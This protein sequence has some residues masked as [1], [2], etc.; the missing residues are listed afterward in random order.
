MRDIALRFRPVA[1]LLVVGALA[2]APSDVRAQ[3]LN[4][5]ES[6]VSYLRVLGTAG[7]AHGPSFTVLQGRSWADG[8]AILVPH[9][10]EDRLTLSPT[11]TFADGFGDLGDTR[12]RLVGNSR[13]PRG[14]NDGAVWS[15]RGLT[16][17]LDTRATLRWHGLSAT[18]NPSV[19]FNQ[20]AS[21][22]LV[23]VQPAGQPSYAYPW[24]R[25]DYPQRFGPQSYWTF[26]LGQS[27]IALDW[28]SG[29]VSFGN[30]SLWW[31]P[32]IRNAIVL[33][34]NAPGFLHATLGTNRPVDIGIGTLEGQWIW[35]GLGQS[36]YFD[37][38]APTDRYITGLVLAY[39]PIWL[40]GFTVGGTR[41]FQSYVPAG[42][43]PL[44]DYFL[45]VQGL[46][47]TSQIS[48]EQPEGTDE[49]DQMVSIFARWVFPESGAEV[50]GEWA[51]TDHALDFEDFLQEPEH[52]Q[53]YTLG[54]QKV[55]ARSTDRI[56][57]LTGELTH[58]EASTTFQL[59]PRPTYYEH[60]VVTQ[61]Y[62]HKGQILGAWVGP[63]GNSQ[64]LGFEMFD[65]WGSAEVFL[66][67]QVHD[68]DAFWVWAEAND[69]TFDAHH[70]S[71]DLGLNA[72][73]FK[74]D[75]DLGGGA[76]LTRQINRWFYGPHLWNL[77]LNLSARW[78]PDLN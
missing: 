21:F 11:V 48:E 66:Q 69:Q 13:L 32:G 62:T 75:F 50:Y 25:I 30:E 4:V 41:V 46:T 33:S 20:N 71:F 54:L 55:T 45:V 58:L 31:G 26:D 61:G 24:R 18:F 35:G 28:K 6:T 77:N 68:N 44:G 60:S 53:G 43:V 22:D 49:A 2:S 14:W 63:G 51:R 74:G 36:D 52:S 38:S 29:R 3:L 7:V 34:N 56:F 37:P 15:G 39:S 19:I 12:L 16:T 76:V 42:G 23:P 70:V 40:D 27:N 72:L 5:G 59:R 1:L 65:R 57:V 17:A 47:K 9:P 10:W 67:R 8:P 78:R 73:I 64:Y